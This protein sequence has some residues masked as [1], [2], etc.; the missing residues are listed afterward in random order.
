MTMIRR[1]IKRAKDERGAAI[2]EFALVA[3]IL[4]T[5]VWGIIETG[6]AFYTIN[7]LASAVRDGARYGAAN[8]PLQTSG[9]GLGTPAIDIC[10]PAIRDMVRTAFQPI[11]DTLTDPNILVLVQG[12]GPTTRIEVTANYP[13]EPIVPIGGWNVTI[14]RRAVFR[15]ERLP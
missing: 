8:C 10:R 11:G 13:Y 2:V 5:L 12:S 15:Y 4:L 1:L 14:T 6:R 7:S 3:P 9:P